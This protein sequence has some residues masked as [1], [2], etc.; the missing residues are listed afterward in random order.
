MAAVRM[1]RGFSPVYVA[2]Q[3]YVKTLD[4]ARPFIRT[5]ERVYGHPSSHSDDSMVSSGSRDEHASLKVLFVIGADR[6]K[7]KVKRSQGRRGARGGGSIGHM[8]HIRCSCIQHIF[9]DSRQCK[10]M[11]S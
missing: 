4:T 10:N 2:P 11:R 5:K 1:M 3:R 8:V 7:G 6:R 9:H